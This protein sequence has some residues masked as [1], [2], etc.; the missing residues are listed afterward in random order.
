[1]FTAAKRIAVKKTVFPRKN[2][3]I[4]LPVSWLN[5]FPLTSLS[6]KA[7]GNP[8]SKTAAGHILQNVGIPKK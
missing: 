8:A 5:S 1:M 7:W 4:N 6:S 2:Q 3:P